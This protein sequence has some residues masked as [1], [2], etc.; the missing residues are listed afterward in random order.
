[1]RLAPALMFTVL[2]TTGAHAADY[3]RG[4]ISPE[5]TRAAT[6][7]FDWSGA[8]VGINAIFNNAYVD[9]RN[10]S[11]PVAGA[12][13]PNTTVTTNVPPLI[14]F[15]NVH[16]TGGGFGGYFGYNTQW[17]DIVLGAEIDYNQAGLRARSGSSTI[18]RNLVDT[19]NTAQLWDTTLGGEANSHIRDITTAKL[20]VGVAYFDRFLPFVSGGISIGRISSSA[21]TTGT[22]QL[23]ELQPILDPVTSQIIG[24]SR[25]NLTGVV[26][27]NGYVKDSGW[28][29]GYNL[30]AGMDVGLTENII[31]RGAWEYSTFGTGRVRTAVN[32]FKGGAAI[33]F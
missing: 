31:L 3:L 14:H 29:W 5:P 33:K 7:S 19:A 28:R 9:Q 1:M 30:G 13:F 32:S 4:P 27:G 24:Y 25:I 11:T 8:Y 18:S 21:S 6:S 16:T 12:T 20:R 17:D 22:T 26:P 23:F 2:A 15:G 10:M